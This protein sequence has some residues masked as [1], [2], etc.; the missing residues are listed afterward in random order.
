METTDVNQIERV[1]IVDEIL[2]HAV[3][4]EEDIG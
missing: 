2:L 4:N 3:D 1:V